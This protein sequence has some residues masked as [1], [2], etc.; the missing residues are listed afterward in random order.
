MA[1]R[2]RRSETAKISSIHPHLRSMPV[3]LSSL[4]RVLHSAYHCSFVAN[5]KLVFTPFLTKISVAIHPDHHVLVCLS[6]HIY[7]E[8]DSLKSH[9]ANKHNISEPDFDAQLAPLVTQ[10]AIVSSANDIYP[11]PPIGPP[12]EG[13]AAIYFG[14]RCMHPGC[15]KAFMKKDIIR[16]HLHDKEKAPYERCHVQTLFS[17]RPIHYFAVNKAL[18]LTL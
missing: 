3:R 16:K 10:Y 5:S 13:V 15:T 11:P 9:L 17:P 7:W 2:R 8:P 18:T 1:K 4:F 14:F 6:C 12:V